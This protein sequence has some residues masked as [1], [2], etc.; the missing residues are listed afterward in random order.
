MIAE[1]LRHC[2]GIG[3]IRLARLH[4]IG[5]RSWWDVLDRPQRIPAGL[6]SGLVAE[7]RRC[8][9]ALEAGDVSYFVDRFT[10]S[11]KWRI[12]AHFFERTSF[13]DIET[14]GLEQHAPITVIVC[15]HRSR[16]WSFVEHENLDAFLELLED[17]TL[18]ASFNGGSFDVPRVCDAFHIP[19]LPCPHL[20][21]RWACYHQ[22]M[23]GGLKEIAASL[24]FARPS[25]LLDVDGEEA[26]RLWTGWRQHQDR[27]ARDGLIRYCAADVLLLLLIAARLTG[28]RGCS[29]DWA[30][31]QLPSGPAELVDRQPAIRPTVSLDAGGL[32]QLR[33]RGMRRVG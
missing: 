9:D 33:A 23:R 21:L 28:Q 6:R 13:F 17:V 26:I 29:P 32:Q 10:G 12:L 8:A 30:W 24:G 16:L 2:A 20:D 3:P 15:W 1:A 18:L 25:D 7:S 5:V 14:M 19:Q 11:D 31:G 22:G 4:E 27:A